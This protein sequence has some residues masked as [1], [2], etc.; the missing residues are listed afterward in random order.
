[1]ITNMENIIKK[2]KEWKEWCDNDEDQMNDHIRDFF[3]DKLTKAELFK[4][5]DKISKEYRDDVAL[6]DVNCKTINK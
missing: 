2:I 4:I 6:F 1:M 3:E 5:I